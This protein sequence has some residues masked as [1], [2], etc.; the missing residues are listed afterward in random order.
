MI[1]FGQLAARDPACDVTIAWTLFAGESREAF[2]R[3]L[4]ADEVTWARGR[5]W[6]LW[7]AL[8]RL[9]EQREVSPVEAAASLQVIDDILAESPSV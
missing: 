7:K 1:D 9:R 2:R 3:R 5:G 4:I 6:G 8:F